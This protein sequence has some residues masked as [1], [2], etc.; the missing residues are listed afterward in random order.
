MNLFYCDI[1]YIVMAVGYNISGQPAKERNLLFH[2][3]NKGIFST[4]KTNVALKYDSI[5]SGDYKYERKH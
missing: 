3:T 1:F 4:C 2:S 5:L